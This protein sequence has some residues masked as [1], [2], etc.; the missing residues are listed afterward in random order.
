[1]SSRYHIRRQEDLLRNSRLLAGHKQLSEDS[2]QAK[3]KTEHA[4]GRFSQLLKWALDTKICAP[5]APASNTSEPRNVSC[6]FCPYQWISNNRS[7]YFFS[8]T[9]QSWNQS[10][11]ECQKEQA[12]L[13]VIV[14]REEQD[15]LAKKQNWVEYWIGLTDA[16]Q[17]ALWTWVDGTTLNPM[18][19]FWDSPQ[20]DNYLNNEDCASLTSKQNLHNWN[21][22]PCNKRYFYI[23]EKAADIVTF[24]DL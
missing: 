8:Q 17:E 21:D 18:E 7:C 9:A 16:K 1:M 10:R 24:S 3:S 19:S 4:E 5:A 20:P 6:S 23:C 12:D 15:F 2:K 14:D 11:K 13:V 22:A